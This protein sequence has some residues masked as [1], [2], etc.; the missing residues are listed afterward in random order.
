MGPPFSK[1]SERTQNHMAL[2]VSGLD[3]E[4]QLLGR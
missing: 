1:N 3:Q 4:T 2:I